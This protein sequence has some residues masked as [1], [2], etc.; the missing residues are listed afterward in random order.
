MGGTKGKDTR[1]E[2][3]R[4]TEPKRQKQKSSVR[5]TYIQTDRDKARDVKAVDR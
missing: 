3:Y 4:K 5:D 2:R 1:T